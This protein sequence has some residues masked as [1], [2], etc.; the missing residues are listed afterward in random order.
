MAIHPRGFTPHHK[1]RPENPIKTDSPGMNR[2]RIIGSLT[3]LGAGMLGGAFETG[4][5]RRR[6]QTAYPELEA[7]GRPG[8]L[9]L[10]H[11]RIF[12][13]QIEYNL[14]FYLQW[15]SQAGR[16]PEDHLRQLAA[17]FVPVIEDRFPALIDEM[18]GIARGAGR[19]L[20][21][22][23]LLNARTDISAI[24]EREVEKMKTPAC[25]SLALFGHERDRTLLALG[26]NWDWDPLMAGAPVV[27]RLTPADAP[28]LV[29]LV[30]AG[31]VAK[32]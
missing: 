26:Q 24:V 29:T 14:S 13:R 30:E 27:L 5:C 18:D 19:S 8:D 12:S 17:S 6:R 16:V 4:S 15:L 2:R 23:A 3:L 31:M 22:I 9:G 20:T 21:E 7:R 25:T 11:G 32:I 1:R 28:R 10:K